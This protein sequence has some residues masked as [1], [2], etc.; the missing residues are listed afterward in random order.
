MVSVIRN[1]KFLFI[2]VVVLVALAIELSS[3]GKPEPT[4]PTVKTPPVSTLQKSIIGKT[5]TSEIERLPRVEK[6]ETL[7][8]GDTRY[9]LTS[10]IPQ[11]PDEIIT[12]GGVSVFERIDVPQ[13]PKA[14]GYARITQFVKVYGQPEKL[15]QGSAF[16]GPFTSTYIYSTRG[17]AFIANP[18]TD[19]I[20]EIQVFASMPV[21]S[22]IEM[23]GDDIKEGPPLEEPLY[24]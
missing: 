4:P 6:K 18:H 14:L 24:P 10:F 21:A 11:R 3:L 2:S 17:F 12:K 1:K 16:F 5:T 22:Y 15:I 20:Y 7:P 19:E 23:Y 8:N 9:E 13:N